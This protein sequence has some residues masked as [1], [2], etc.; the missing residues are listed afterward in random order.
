MAVVG[1][2]L[3]RGVDARTALDN[4]S[5][6]ADVGHDDFVVNCRAVL[7]VMAVHTS[8]LRRATIGDDEQSDHHFNRE[9]LR[10]FIGVDGVPSR[11][12]LFVS[13]TDVGRTER[14]GA[15]RQSTS[16]FVHSAQPNS[17]RSFARRRDVYGET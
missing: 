12:R 17:T 10:W 7:P 13:L 14:G 15:Q 8:S 3:L 16:E 11:D 9:S 5:N 4:R 6:A 1:C 2:G